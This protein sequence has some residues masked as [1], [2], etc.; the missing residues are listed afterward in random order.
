MNLISTMLRS[1]PLKFILDSFMDISIMAQKLLA[2][3][4][5]ADPHIS[6][7]ESKSYHERNQPPWLQRML[8]LSYKISIL[9]RY[10][11]LTNIS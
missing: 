5:R 7:K 10:R 6:R 9:R 3:L 8:Y 11:A 1:L 2:N 4:I